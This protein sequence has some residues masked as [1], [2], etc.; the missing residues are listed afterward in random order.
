MMK[1]NNWMNCIKF[2]EVK[3]DRFVNIYK[4]IDIYRMKNYELYWK[5]IHIGSLT[6]T[7]WDMRSS[8]DILYHFD[9]SSEDSE[10]S[11]LA[12]SIRHSIKASTYFDEIGDDEIYSQMC[13]EEEQYLD[14][15]NSSDWYLL[16][17]KGETIKILC[18]IFHDNNEITWQQDF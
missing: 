18:P 8:G 13:E 14:I 7:N 6:E 11:F 4:K 15:I 5:E 16:N 17:D 9:F 2:F 1:W 12:A 10:N 3:P